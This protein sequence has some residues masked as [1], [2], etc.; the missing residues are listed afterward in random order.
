M[1][2]IALLVHPPQHVQRNHNG[3]SLAKCKE[4]NTTLMDEKRLPKMSFAASLNKC[5]VLMGYV[6]CEMSPL[7]EPT[8]TRIDFTTVNIWQ[9]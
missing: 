4:H 6:L 7:Y 9:L 2:R 8:M 5:L 3:M 1:I